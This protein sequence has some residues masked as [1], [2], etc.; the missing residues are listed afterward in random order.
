MSEI[1]TIITQ[2][3][4]K[5]LEKGPTEALKFLKQHKSHANTTEYLQTIGELYLEEGKPDKA[6]KNLIKAMEMD[7][8][9]EKGY[10][11]FFYLGQIIGG[12]NGVKLINQGLE[13]I[14]V[15]LQALATAETIDDQLVKDFNFGIFTQVEIWMTDLCMAPEAEEKCVELI[16]KA[17]EIDGT[18]GEAWALFGSIKVSQSK[19][20][21]AVECF[22]KAWEL[23]QEK[24]TRIANTVD[25]ADDF[26]AQVIELI[27]PVVNLL[28]LGV[29]LMQ[30]ETCFDIAAFVKELDEEIVEALYLSGFVIY[31]HFKKPQYEATLAGTGTE[32]NFEDFT[33]F[34]LD[35]NKIEKNDE[36]ILYLK[37]LNDD[38]S[39][40]LKIQENGNEE[41]DPDVLGHIAALI[42]EIKESDSGDLFNG[43][44]NMEVTEE[45]WEDEI[46]YD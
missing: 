45:N 43:L 10:G 46:E 18:N 17:L 23:F 35:L 41:V 12:E 44:D 36:N 25:E 7:P 38:F 30:F 11:K 1:A 15:K 33:N 13:L 24:K 29:E 4:V 34:K 21:E 20:E 37:T 19:P 8:Q 6:Y 3:R 27:Q 42:N 31:L 28:K 2:T 14:Y 9:G 26:N 5:L 40:V 16:S 39:K 32:F 22:N